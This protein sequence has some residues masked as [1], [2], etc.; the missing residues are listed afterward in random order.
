M[1]SYSISQVL[2]KISKAVVG[3]F[4]I[5]DLQERVVDLCQDIFEARDCSLFLFDENRQELRLVA[6]RGYSAKFLDYPDPIFE[7]HQQVVEK[8]AD[9]EKVGITG[10]IAATGRSFMS[11]SFKEL[12]EHPHWRGVFDEDRLGSKGVHSFYGVPLKVADDE[13][14]G[15]L[16]IENKRVEGRGQPFTDD[17][18]HIFD[19]LAAYIA[20]TIANARRVGE[21]KRQ[22]KQLQTITDALQQVVSSLSEELPMQH[23]LD[24]IVETTATV[25]G[26]EAC[27]L[28]LK[29]DQRDVLVERAGVG[30]VAQLIGKA[31]YALIPREELAEK[32]A[33]DDEKVG[34]TAWIAITGNPFLAR[35]NA[36]LQKHP[37]WRG[38]YDPEHYP[39]GQGKRCQSFLGVPLLV[40]DEI[41]GVLK[42]ENKKVGDSYVPLTDQDRLVFEVLARS[43][44][45]AIGQIRKQ[46][47]QRE[48]AVTDAMYR[49]S[50]ALAGRLE[51]EPLLQEIVKV[52]KEIFNAEACVIFLVD[53]ADPDR[54]VETKGE[55]YVKHLEGIAEYH[56]IP[57]DAL[58]EQPEQP[59]D[60]VGLTAWIAITGQ[61]FLARN[62]AE[63]R[64]HPHWRG[65]YD[66]EHYQA[67]S[68]KQ[69]NSFLG[70]PLRVGDEILGVLKVENKQDAGEYV[71]F[72]ERD[73]Q[74][75]QLLA[76]SAAITIRNTRDFQKLQETQQ[77]A[78]IGRSAAAMAHHMRTPLQEIRITAELLLEDLE[79]RKHASAKD[80][81]DIADILGA[82]ER[83]NDAVERVREA[84][85][86]LGPKL[87]LYDIGEIIRNS[88]TDNNSFAKQFQ[89]RA[90][91]TQIVGLENLKTSVIR[92]DRNLIEEAI[93]NLINNSLEAIGANGRIIVSVLETQEGLCIEVQ[94]NGGGADTNLTLFE[95]FNTNKEEGLG[96]GLFIVRRN[97]EAHGGVVS[98]E[99]KDKG[100][101]FRIE[102]PQ[103][104]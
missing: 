69:C 71:P 66:P 68:G 35:N 20:T 83:M 101:C 56:L 31:E 6:A 84:A 45:I 82:V 93:S 8:P 60:R 81:E 88:F 52:G 77:L 75:F 41:V 104:E 95:P 96:L 15:V 97:I 34:L 12:K 16:K 2:G 21:I 38:K 102:L 47:V 89:E 100:A 79:E 33:T 37:H 85:K 48:Q 91:S 87:D 25:L 22:S 50:E 86:P 14:I 55:G 61:P 44:A 36:E 29:D 98:Y 80:R 72:D 5:S 30:Y 43:I 40:A 73:Q 70:L 94:D 57:P 18:A 74:L 1:T 26:A 27:V 78:S 19:I 10:W 76:N 32:P 17:D 28:F 63:L 65:R 23:L 92:C 90:I 64:D 46:R 4:S 53:P 51:T 58:I 49:V 13:I 24:E 62:N 7:S 99:E 59:E 67:G 54:L 11:N 42:V 39:E 9:D 3:V 103:H